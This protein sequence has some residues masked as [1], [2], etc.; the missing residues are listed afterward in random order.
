M[1]TPRRQGAGKPA[2]RLRETRRPQKPWPHQAGTPTPPRQHQRVDCWTN[3]SGASRSFAR[4]AGAPPNDVTPARNGA[5]P[6]GTG[7]RISALRSWA[8]RRPSG[9]A[10]RV[11]CGC[12]DRGFMTARTSVPVKLPKDRSFRVGRRHGTPEEQTRACIVRFHPRQD[13]GDE[14]CPEITPSP[15]A[16]PISVLGWTSIASRSSIRRHVPKCGETSGWLG[17]P[18]RR[19][20]GI[21]C[22]TRAT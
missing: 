2:P 19:P 18:N 4:C 9:P 10:N 5:S 3:L 8:W 15:C 17:K 20:R 14:H 22:A 16:H 6:G 1:G 11:D 7:C 12:G 13:F 21:I